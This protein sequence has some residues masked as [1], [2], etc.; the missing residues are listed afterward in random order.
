MLLMRHYIDAPPQSE[1]FRRQFAAI[2]DAFILKLE[3]EALRLKVKS[4]EACDVWGKPIEWVWDDNAFRNVGRVGTLADAR[5]F[6]SNMINQGMKFAFACCAQ[7]G[8]KGIWLTTWE[9]PEEGP[10][11]PPHLNVL[12]SEVHEGV[13]LGPAPIS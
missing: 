11:W 5:S 3:T 8:G 6:A 12:N 4:F 13:S 9:Y 1:E 2:T 10:V 7:D